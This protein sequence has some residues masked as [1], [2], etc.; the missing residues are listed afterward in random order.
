MNLD[1]GPK[2]DHRSS[3]KKGTYISPLETNKGILL[4]D[5]RNPA[6]LSFPDNDPL[7]ISSVSYDHTL[8]NKIIHSEKSAVHLRSIFICWARTWKN[9]DNLEKKNKDSLNPNGALH[10]FQQVPGFAIITGE[11][12][13]YL[14]I[15]M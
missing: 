2:H 12:L 5:T 15:L 6:A 13:Q 10:G 11:T 7:V 3:K 9:F 14:S 4:A 1:F 8:W